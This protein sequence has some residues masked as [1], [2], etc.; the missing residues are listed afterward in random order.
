M[1]PSH[2]QTIS[3]DCSCLGVVALQSVPVLQLAAVE[4]EVHVLRLDVA[5]FLGHLLHIASFFALNWIVDQTKQTKRL[6]EWTISYKI[7]KTNRKFLAKKCNAACVQGT[8]SSCKAQFQ[9]KRLES[10]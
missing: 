9:F 5:V 1:F 2:G 4:D 6:Y 3:S 10:R 8:H 7:S